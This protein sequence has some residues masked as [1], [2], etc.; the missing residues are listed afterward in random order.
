MLCDTCFCRLPGAFKNRSSLM[1]TQA[2]PPAS[3]S[4]SVS[5]KRFESSLPSVSFKRFEPSLPSFLPPLRF[6][7]SF[8]WR[9]NSSTWLIA[10]ASSDSSIFTVD[11]SSWS[12][13]SFRT[14]SK[15]RVFTTLQAMVAL[16]FPMSAAFLSCP[17]VNQN[18]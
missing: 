10:Y 5:F 2:C 3:S 1:L 12:R 7:I 14:S 11:S 6:W 18:S 4:P 15:D 8:S 13:S 9:F 17:A 16:A